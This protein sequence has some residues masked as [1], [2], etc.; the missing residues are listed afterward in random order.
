MRCFVLGLGLGVQGVALGTLLAEMA[1]AAVGLAIAA[2]HLRGLGGRWDFGQ[3][4]AADRMR[5]TIAVNR[6]IMIRSAALIVAFAWFMTHSASQ[7][8]TILAANAVLMQF[9]AFAAF[10]L[11]GLAFA[12]EAL[13]GKAVGA[14]DR[15]GL[16]AAMRM[17][18]W[19][20]AGV[21]AAACIVFALTG[22]TVI[23]VLTV[24]EGVRAAARIYLPWAVATP[25][26]SVWAFQLDGIFV[27]ATRTA[28]MRNAMLVALAIFLLAWWL[29]T[30]LHNH[31][32]WAALYVL[33]AARAGTLACYLRALLRSVP[34]RVRS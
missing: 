25:I 1:A 26:V 27:G 20:A 12:A 28:E 11:D 7:G 2:R 32:L 6:D 10:F 9:V 24:D 13:V 23:D 33:Y 21:A 16:H 14:A 29:L 31:G 19:W 4:R 30:P 15:V 22:S 17:T 8:D 34:A 3:L 5:R 18:T